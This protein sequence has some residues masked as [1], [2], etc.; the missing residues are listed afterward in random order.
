M[1]ALLVRQVSRL[2]GHIDTA[3][4]QAPSIRSEMVQF[5]SHRARIRSPP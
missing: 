4:R 5:Q 1:M 2:A 3:E